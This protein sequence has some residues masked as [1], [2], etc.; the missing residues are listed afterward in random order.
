MRYLLLLALAAC[1]KTAP[2][3]ASADASEPE[4]SALARESVRPPPG[5]VDRLPEHGIL[6][7]V[8]DPGAG[9]R[10]PLRLSP[11]P[12]EPITMRSV[13]SLEIAMGFGGRFL[14]K[15]A[16]PPM[17]MDMTVAVDAIDEDGTIRYAVELVS[18]GLGEEP[19]A[20][21][22]VGGSVLTDLEQ[23]VGL[24]GQS[25]IS[26]TGRLLSS[27]FQ[28]P[29]GAGEQTSAHLENMNRVLDGLASP[30]PEDPV[31]V[32]AQW[33]SLSRV[34]S[35]NLEVAQRVMTELVARDGDRLTLDVS[36]YQEPLSWTI[37]VPDMPGVDVAISRFD[38]RGSG[39][40][41]LDLG[42]LVPIASS[43]RL[44]TEMQMT[45]QIGGTEQ[46]TDQRL[47]MDLTVERL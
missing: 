2:A 19:D 33:E 18:V 9:P 42:E 29:A 12:G 3:D 1:A 25:T 47:S 24:T 23:L 14:P 26:A 11:R 13:T 43:S 5:L 39:R 15:T 40:V 36:V 27:D 46:I 8:I 37:E 17:I 28:L 34:A 7:R 30:L 45:M 35:G 20:P 10:Q 21:P 38:S 4:E 31:G 22:E 16:I 44:E 41:E 32:G 6:V